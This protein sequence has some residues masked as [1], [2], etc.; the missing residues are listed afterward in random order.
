MMNAGETQTGPVGDSALRVVTD[1]RCLGYSTPGH[2]ERPSRISRALVLLREQQGLPVYWEEPS[3]VHEETLLRAH[4]AGHV[5]AVL[6][7]TEDFDPDTPWTPDIAQHAWRSVGGALRAM[8]NALGRYRAFSLMRPPGH[9]ATRACAMGFCYCNNVA[10]AVLEAIE[11]GVGR[12]AVL[13]FDVHH[14]NGTEAILL[15]HPQAATYSIHQY[16]AYPGTGYEDVGPNAHNY[17]VAPMTARPE[18]RAVLTRA[19]EDLARFKPELVAVSAGFDAYANDPLAQETLEAEDYHWLG[20]Q[21]RALGL[22]NFSVLEGGYSNDLPQL[23]L[24]YLHGISGLG[25]PE[26]ASASRPAPS[27]GAAV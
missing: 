18:Y 12:V 26:G 5:H 4:T 14:A 15:S 6:S 27:P 23:I 10:V 16:P 9:H 2:P 13:D 17:P 7:A 19:L 21:I 24:A 8:E 3:P 11:R 25:M 20:A 22:P 1:E